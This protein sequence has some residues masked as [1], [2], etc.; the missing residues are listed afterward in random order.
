[1]VTWRLF[2]VGRCIRAAAVLGAADPIVRYPIPGRVGGHVGGKLVVG[3]GPHGG[4]IG[5]VLA[6]GFHGGKFL[7]RIAHDTLFLLHGALS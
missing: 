1:M 5:T 7:I 6:A 2:S 4:P 3:L